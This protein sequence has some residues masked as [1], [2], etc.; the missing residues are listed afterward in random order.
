V[1]E[2]IRR[3]FR[4]SRP[5]DRFAPQ[6]RVSRREREEQQ[7]RILYIAMATVAILVVGLLAGGAIFEFGIQPRQVI[8]SVNGVNITRGDY[9][10]LRRF[11]LG[12]QIA[13]YQFFSSQNPQQYASIIQ[14]LQVDL[15]N[16]KTSPPDPAA[17]Q[18]M[19]D[20]IVVQQNLGD[21]GLAITQTDLDNYIAD[22]FNP[23][24]VNT[25]T[26]TTTV[27]PTV[28]A[29]ATETASAAVATATAQAAA[30]PRGTP[31]TPGTPGATPG[32]PAATPATPAATPTTPG[33]P[34]TPEGTPAVSPTATI[35][36]DQAIA[37]ATAGYANYLKDLEE[38]VDMSRDD[39][40]R[41]VAR[42]QIARQKVTAKLTGEISDVQPQARAV[43]ILLATKAGAEQARQ[44]ILQDPGSFAKI[45]REQSTDTSTNQNGGDLGWFPRGVMV[46]EFED[47]AFSLPID[48]VSEPVQTRFGWHLIK[49]IE[50]SDTRPIAEE[51][52]ASLKE[53]V[54]QKWLDGQKVDAKIDSDNIET[55]PTPALQQFSP[56]PGAPPAPTPTVAPI[57]TPF[58]LTP[59][60]SGVV[61]TP[62]P[63]PTATRQP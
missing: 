22:N 28:R 31:G 35:S 40:V 47:V 21:L 27:N 49:V 60:P 55:T 2:R 44:Q 63:T 53:G 29:W 41:L 19:I 6:R 12:T 52:L 25:P 36:R 15:Q 58:P 54:F 1:I 26:P 38:A 13:Q 56:P 24:V 16:V 17:L 51:T 46:K 33:T 3:R 57:P 48:Q 11:S 23:G 4:P 18:G 32:T 61:P 37:T 62:F 30:T 14:Q 45:A 5:S 59:S 34:G 7:R 10:K 8:A 9:W 39:Y 43:H 20:D 50:K 42:P